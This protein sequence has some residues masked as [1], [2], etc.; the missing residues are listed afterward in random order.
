MIRHFRLDVAPWSHPDLARLDDVLR[1]FSTEL[2]VDL[3]AFALE[4]DGDHFTRDGQR[5]FTEALVRALPTEGAILVLADSTIDF[6]NWS[7]DGEWTGWASSLVRDALPGRDVVVDAVCGSGFVAR[8]GEHFYARLSA[9]LRRGF[10]GTIVVL[11]GWNDQRT[12]RIEETANAMSRF[13][14]LAE[15]YA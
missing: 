6:H 13:A 8:A 10:H 9:H 5:A 3:G 2:E 4:P 1:R 14:S 12:G 11:G 15:R 7:S